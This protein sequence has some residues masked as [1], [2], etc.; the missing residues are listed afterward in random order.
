LINADKPR[1]WKTDIEASVDL[2][3]TWF[4]QSAP[5]AYRTTRIRTTQEVEQAFSLTADLL[6]ITPADIKA[7]PIVLPTLRMSTAPP[8]ARDRLVGLAGTTGTLVKRLEEGKL[9]K[10]LKDAALDAHLEQICR[11]I[12]DLLDV[13]LFPW[14]A[15]RTS[16]TEAQRFRA[17]IIVA[18][19]L[20][21]AIAN[22]I[23]RNAQ[24][25][26]QLAL[27]GNY[28]KARG[29]AE[30]VHPAS[31]ALTEMPAGTF[32]CRMNVMVRAGAIKVPMDVVIQ[33]R[34]PRPNR[35]PILVEAKSAGDFTNTNKR[36]KE[37]AQ[38]IRQI[39]ETFGDETDFILFLCGY[40]STR[41]LGYEAAEGM[42]WVWEHRISDLDQ[43]GI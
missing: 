10:K 12:S 13:D 34:T 36:Q 41:Y 8:L 26:R 11:V 15:S 18:D 31:Q 27:I 19:R 16:P 9:P 25:Q 32:A 43:L 42:D 22:P 5:A 6:N 20:C 14:I 38:K 37:E 21:G 17:A 1:Q 4:M 3:N 24:E 29:Y 2:F 33:P 28:L 7:N 39:R 40:F 30:K 35:L 23:V